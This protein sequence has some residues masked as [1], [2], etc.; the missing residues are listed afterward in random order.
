MTDFIDITQ[1]SVAVSCLGIILIIFTFRVRP[2]KSWESSSRLKKALFLISG[3]TCQIPVAVSIIS[4]PDIVTDT[5]STEPWNW[6]YLLMNY[7]VILLICIVVYG[8]ER[9]FGGYDASK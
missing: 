6:R 8:A 7:L 1:F 9:I 4:K 3:L 5:L 2:S